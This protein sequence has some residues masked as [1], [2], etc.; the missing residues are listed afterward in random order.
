VVASGLENILP[1]YTTTTTNDKDPNSIATYTLC[2]KRALVSWRD[3]NQYK[4]GV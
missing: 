1:L 4:N 3:K 2:T